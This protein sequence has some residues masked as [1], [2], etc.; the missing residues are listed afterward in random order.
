MEPQPAHL[1]NPIP[2]STIQVTPY[3]GNY[4]LEGEQFRIRADP[5]PL[6]DFELLLGKPMKMAV[7]LACY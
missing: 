2:L 1:A 6:S 3:K 4:A 5:I 7:K